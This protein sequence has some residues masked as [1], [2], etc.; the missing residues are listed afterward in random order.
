MNLSRLDRMLAREKLA[1]DPHID[2][3]F[4]FAF[5]PI[6]DAEKGEIASYEALVRGPKGE[7]APDV[8]GHLNKDNL[9][10]FD[11]ACRTKAIK[12]A[13]RLKLR[14]NLHINLL[15][16]GN[17]LTNINIHETFKASMECG[18]PLEHIVFEI[19]E[20]ETL[21]DQRRLVDIIKLYRDFSFQTAID[22][23]GTG[24]SGLKLLIEYQPNYVKLDR[25]LIENIHENEIKQTILQGINLICRKLNIEMMAEGVEKVEEYSWLRTLGVKFFQGF[26]FAFPAFEALPEVPAESFCV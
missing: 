2:F 22:D 10:E 6:V 8:L 12:L 5:Q 15:P 17:Y 13:S 20:S 19:T 14:Q 21:T 23:F 16:F 25:Y 1:I 4:S 18:F 3:E 9:Y 11:R 7:P 24:Y 26:Y